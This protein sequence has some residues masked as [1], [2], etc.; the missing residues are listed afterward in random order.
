MQGTRQRIC[1]RTHSAFM[2]IE[3]YGYISDLETGALVGRN[4]SVDW[5]CV[6]RF[7]SPS[8]FT[9]LLGDEEN[10]FWKIAPEHGGMAVRRKYRDDTLILES[11]FE[12][13]GGCVR[14]TDFMALRDGGPTLVRVVDGVRG[15][16]PMEMDFRVR[17]DYGS[18]RPVVAPCEGGFTFTA[19]PDATVL[20]GTLPVDADRDGICHR[21]S[22]AEGE[23]HVWSLEWYAS[24]SK[25]P[26]PNDPLRAL[27]KTEAFWKEWSQRLTC[28]GEWKD[29]V[30]RSAMV[31][32]ALTYQPT[33]GVIAAPTTS[34]PEKI[35][36][37]RNWDYRFC[38]LRDAGLTFDAMLDAGY[39]KEA[40]EWRDWLVRAI[41]G[42]PKSTQIVYGLGGERRLPEYE[43]KH[44]V[45][46]EGSKPVNVGNAA[47]TQLQLDIY[48]QVLDTMY[49]ARHAGVENC[50][51]SWQI[52]K[53]LVEFVMDNWRER[54]E[55]IWEVRLDRQHF[56]HSKIM[57]WVALDRAVKSCEEHGLDG[58]LDKWRAVREEIHKD[59]C[60]RGFNTKVGA[61]TLDDSREY[62]D[63]SLLIIPVVGFLPADDER[64]RSTVEAIERKL[65]RGGFVYRYDT[66]EADKIDGLPP[67]EGAFLPCSFWMVD[68]LNMMGRSKDARNLFERL[69]DVRN[70]LGLLS[71]EYD[72][73]AKRMLG[74]FPQAFS[75]VGLINSACNLMH[76][77]E[78]RVARSD[79]K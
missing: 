71:E 2:K 59:V 22:L 25:I 36:G 64:V 72:P 53:E 6:P 54:D 68:A 74:N 37:I 60:E 39:T 10:G 16:V 3:D 76:E 47:A 12:D 58:D 40:S 65:M 73:E 19:G 49:E 63:G 43:L 57:A 67:G 52:Q 78:S 45:G 55:G 20:R 32:K 61:F 21:F 30:A 46:Y 69:L 9:K 79:R 28:K 56:T 77:G 48:G 18:V 34:L 1:M 42:S 26:S 44:L 23:R 15:S 17:Y 70:D 62:L 14:L 24:H 41:G 13:A 11:E 8:C 51:D 75:H 7:D 29:A 35:G 4:G 33:G 66:D 50:E 27:E 31:L 5:Y 38:W